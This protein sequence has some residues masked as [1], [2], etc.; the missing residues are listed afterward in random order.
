M[1]MIG[2]V[3]LRSLRESCETVL[4]EHAPGDLIETG[5]WRGGACII[6]A[7]VLA[8]H[9]D[10]TRTV[11]GF[12]SFQGLPPPDE[13]KYPQDRGDQLFRFPQLAVSIEEVVENFWRM[14]LWNERARPVKG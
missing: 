12:N 9:E 11:S 2:R 10:K 1:T 8:A 5:I 3:R 4:H 7:A 6:M 14:G 13:A